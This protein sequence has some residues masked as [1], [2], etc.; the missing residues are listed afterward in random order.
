MKQSVLPAFCAEKTLTIL[1]HA[2][3]KFASNATKSVTWLSTAKKP[4][5]SNVID[6][7]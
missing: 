3:R 6:V 1:F 2:P 4:T 5:L 7:D